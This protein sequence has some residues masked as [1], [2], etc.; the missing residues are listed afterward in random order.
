MRRNPRT[1]PCGLY[2]LYPNQKL[3]VKDP[4]DSLYE[5]GVACFVSAFG[6]ELVSVSNHLYQIGF[7]IESVAVPV[8]S[9]CE[10][11]VSCFVSGFGFV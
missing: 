11:G 3:Y 2:A 9:L 4:V 5:T 6:I 1:P 10:T 7:S 8:G